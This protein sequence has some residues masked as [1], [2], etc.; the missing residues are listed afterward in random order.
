MEWSVRHISWTW[1]SSAE[2]TAEPKHVLPVQIETDRLV[3]RKY[4]SGDGRCYYEM[5]QRNRPYLERY[6]SGN[7]AMS[8]ESEH[9]AEQLVRKFSDAWAVGRQYFIGVFLKRTGRF[10]AQLYV[11][12]AESELS[13]YEVGYFA[14]VDSE[15]NGY[16]TEAVK[17]VIDALFDELGARTIRIECDDTNTRSL[18]LAERCGFV[19]TSHVPQNKANADGSRSGTVHFG[20]SRESHRDA[21]ITR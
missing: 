5:S 3:L 4:Q 11:G 10:V 20:L 12:T 18:A 7:P 13:E 16:V 1:W 19:L 14:D 6:E 15:E 2:T 9:G 8:I 17:R 21:A